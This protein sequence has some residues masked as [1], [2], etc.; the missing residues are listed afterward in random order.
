M[1]FLANFV[2]AGFTDQKLILAALCEQSPHQQRRQRYHHHHRSYQHSDLEHSDNEDSES[3]RQY[4]RQRRP[5]SVQYP[6]NITDT[7]NHHHMQHHHHH[8]HRKHQRRQASNDQH[9]E[10][11]PSKEPTIKM[12]TLQV[13]ARMIVRCD[14]GD[15][16]YYCKPRF[17]YSTYGRAYGTRLGVWLSVC[18]SVTHVLWLMY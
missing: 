9:L 7:G 17:S 5:S 13:C 10:P 16:G 14:R 8:H 1:P 12:D 2:D 11:P 4:E 18:L 3:L 6:P 15:R